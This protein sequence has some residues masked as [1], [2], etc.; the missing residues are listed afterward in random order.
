MSRKSPVQSQQ[1]QREGDILRSDAT[2]SSPAVNLTERFAED[3]PFC[4]ESV[5]V[6]VWEALLANTDTCPIHTGGG[7][8]EMDMSP[9]GIKG[10]SIGR[11]EDRG[12]SKGSPSS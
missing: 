10:Q 3:E 9:K 12:I 11:Q 1:H 5:A 7:T 2:H 4:K 6:S 8:H